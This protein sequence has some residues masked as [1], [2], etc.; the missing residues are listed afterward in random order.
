[1]GWRHDG[2][3][4]GRM[5][6]TQNPLRM[7]AE[8][9]MTLKSGDA[10][11]AGIYKRCVDARGQCKAR[12]PAWPRRAETPQEEEMMTPM[13][14]KMFLDFGEDIK[15]LRVK[16]LQ[17]M[18]DNVPEAERKSFVDQEMRKLLMKYHP[19]YKRMH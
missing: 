12:L 11:M 18:K 9:G 5:V 14:P 2:P 6:F 10:T 4:M 15:T 16:V 7:R 8:G 19:K 17:M 3:A 1:M 13:L